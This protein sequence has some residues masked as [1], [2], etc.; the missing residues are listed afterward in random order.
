LVKYSE[1]QTAQSV[2]S[3]NIGTPTGTTTIA[4]Y[5]TGTPPVTFQNAADPV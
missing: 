5:A 4:A 2:F 3:E 1:G